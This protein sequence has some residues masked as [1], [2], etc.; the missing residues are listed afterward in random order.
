MRKRLLL[1]GNYP[2][3]YGGVPTHIKY[4]A[5]YLAARD[6][7][8]HVVSFVGETPGIEQQAGYTV[9]RFVRRS[10]WSRLQRVA[11]PDFGHIGRHYPALLRSP[12]LG[13][14]WLATVNFVRE[15]ICDHDIQLVSAY[16]IL[17][18][19]MIGALLADELGTRLVTTIFGEIYSQPA[20]HRRHLH[21]VRYVLNRSQ[22]VLSCSHHCAESLKLLGF[23]TPVEAIHYGIDTS[24]FAPGRGGAALRMRLGIAPGCPLVLFVAR[25]VREMGLD[26]LLAAIPAVL[27]ARPEAVFLLAGTHGELTPEALALAAR[28]PRQIFVLP[29]VPYVDLPALYDAC[30]FSVAPSVNARAC[31]GLAI[32]EAM[33][34]ERAVIG[35][36]VGG[37]AEVIAEG[38]TGLLVAPGE[39]AA[40]ADAIIKLV[41]DEARRVD[42]GKRGRLRALE[43]FDKDQ[44][45]RRME[46]LFEEVVA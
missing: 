30:S 27:Q 15:L 19:G 14:N 45:N 9:H 22:R 21:E 34:T 41:D 8:L 7:D 10:R 29:D 17:G 20:L 38:V 12:R 16:H 13:L 23:E 4:L 25:M 39:V 33:A 11:W 24:R 44:T 2:P 5:D 3:P 32:A 40:L 37:T 36:R 43:M 42:L 35:A 6:W 31:L 46:Q 26:V 1:L 28:H 18:A